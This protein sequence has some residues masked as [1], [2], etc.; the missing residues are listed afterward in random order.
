M[1]SA[2]R[3]EGPHGAEPRS[4]AKPQFVVFSFY[5]VDPVWRRL[6]KEDRQSGKGEF[7]RVLEE[8]RK[9]DVLIHT[10]STVGTRADTELMLWRIGYDLEVIQEMT[11]SLLGTG[12]GSYLVATHSYLALAK[13]STYVDKLD[14]GH[15]ES[16]SVIVPGQMKYLFV[17]PFVKKREWYLMSPAARQ[18]IMDEHIQVGSKYISVKLN[19]TYSFG[20]DDQEFVVAFETDE[21]KDFLDLVMELR[22]TEGS[23][24]TERDTPIFTCLRR[25]PQAA[26]DLLGG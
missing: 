16:R 3:A 10:Y 24:Y 23:R 1:R 9:Q 26:L 25:E 17:Y 6:P 19:T 18:G 14:P 15:Q 4:A 7:L 21:P 20:L 12:L 8:Y 2:N 11:G 13:R 22:E 5:K